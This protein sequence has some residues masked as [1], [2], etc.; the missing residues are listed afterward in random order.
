MLKDS[1]I[2]FEKP[3]LV[4][5]CGTCGKAVTGISSLDSG[6]LTGRYLREHI[7]LCHV[8]LVESIAPGGGK[9][10]AAWRRHSAMLSRSSYFSLGAS[11]SS[12]SGASTFDGQTHGGGEAARFT[13]EPGTIIGGVYEVISTLGW[14]GMGT[15][16][17]VKHK[18]LERISAVKVLDSRLADANAWKRFQVEAR[19]VASLNH[20]ALVNVYD[21]G[22]HEGKTPFFVMDFV[23]GVS[24]EALLLEGGPLFLE[25]VLRIFDVVLD[26]LAYTHKA[27]IIHR[28]IKPANIMVSVDTLGNTTV[29]LLDFGLAKLSVEAL[30]GMDL[31]KKATLP[32]SEDKE[33]EDRKE[34]ADS[35]SPPDLSKTAAHMHQFLTSHDEVFGSPHYMSPEQCQG[36]VVDARSDIY[37]AGC[38]IFE[39][40]TGEVPFEGR[41]ALETMLMHQEDTPPSLQEKSKHLSKQ[42]VLPDVLEQIVARCLC[43]D[44]RQR[45]QNVAALKSDLAS[46]KDGH[47]LR[48]LVMFGGAAEQANIS[49]ATP[50]KKKT[51]LLE[52]PI[53]DWNSYGIAGQL[54]LLSI[55]IAAC[56]T[57]FFVGYWSVLALSEQIESQQKSLRSDRQHSLL[58]SGAREDNGTRG[59]IEIVSGAIANDTNNVNDLPDGKL[60]ADPAF[61]SPGE[62][63]LVLVRPDDGAVS[64][65]SYL[66]FIPPELC[67]FSKRVDVIL[68]PGPAIIA[69]PEKILK[70][71]GHQL[72]A[73]DLGTLPAD[74]SGADSYFEKSFPAMV[75][76]LNKLPNIHSLRITATADRALLA[77]EL[78]RLKYIRS[79]DLSG[80]SLSVDDL[81]GLPYFSK[82]ESLE[83]GPI[84]DLNQSSKLIKELKHC[85]KLNRLTLSNC[86]IKDIDLKKI[87]PFSQIHTLALTGCTILSSTIGE[88]D[89]ERYARFPGVRSLF[90]EDMQ[91]SEE[92]TRKL[93]T[94]NPQLQ[95]LT[96]VSLDPSLNAR[97]ARFLQLKTYLSEQANLRSVFVS[98][99]RRNY[100]GA[101][102]RYTDHL[103]LPGKY[104]EIDDN[105]VDDE[106]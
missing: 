97:Q 66:H 28:D 53:P 7:C 21:L 6:T 54:L 82:L 50:A 3:E 84:N 18:V 17:K 13:F 30:T 40:L 99:R 79:L 19:S 14:G 87:S 86:V 93:I 38:S 89:L 35:T 106:Q 63:G 69:N 27:G 48:H 41:N 47:K 26:C 25:D 11:G 68:R 4:T 57:V 60:Y 23:E 56:L 32:V 12:K 98:N 1:K 49:D 36:G 22:L 72:T 31:D 61:A 96:I 59:I 15:V 29:K 78:K 9:Q 10:T 2:K 64:T 65:S 45:Y 20:R 88:A 94:V 80:T 95:R 58:H 105:L 90:L 77:K 43:K 62:Y 55:A 37:S 83:I 71:K 8:S 24:L 52:L 70:M 76:A 81:I 42:Q 33:K 101:F 75:N 16:Y 92:E 102:D 74:N 104:Q 67:D 5:V 103:R 91:L 51:V 44:P 34:R 39:A 73:L 85:K 100:T 46:I